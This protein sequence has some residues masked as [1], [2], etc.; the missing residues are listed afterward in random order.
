M[1]IIAFY[2]IKKGTC[3]RLKLSI[4]IMPYLIIELLKRQS[5][6]HQNIILPLF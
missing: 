2:N 3:N 1:I 6:P 5:L 4:V